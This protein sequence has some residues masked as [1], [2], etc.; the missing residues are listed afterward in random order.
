[1][2][3]NQGPWRIKLA[4]MDKIDTDIVESRKTELSTIR[5]SQGPG[6]D[7]TW[8]GHALYGM[9]EEPIFY[10]GLKSLSPAICIHSNEMHNVAALFVYW[11][12]G[13]SSTCFGP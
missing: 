2:N 4:T 7:K 8:K 5:N 9:L 10:A 1:M 3:T 12:I 6:T 13:V 11:C